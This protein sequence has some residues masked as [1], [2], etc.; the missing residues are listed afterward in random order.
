MQQFT[1]VH[2]SIKR[3][4]RL[5]VHCVY[6]TSKRTN[7]TRFGMK[8]FFFIVFHQKNNF[9][10]T[11]LG[12]GSED[13]MCMDFIY[14]YPLME[15]ANQMPFSLCGSLTMSDFNGTVCGD[16]FFGGNPGGL[17][18]E[19]NPRTPDPR[20]ADFD[21]FLNKEVWGHPSDVRGCAIFPEVSGV[22][23]NR[24]NLY[25]LLFI[26]VVVSFLYLK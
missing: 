24:P 1:P 12:L 23:R 16:Y 20:L 22:F 15:T 19:G 14:Y 2:Y 25:F 3:G 11:L 17:I 10:C 6:D 4:D 5:H 9:F 21:Y 13:E 8:K 26:S 7:T 18:P